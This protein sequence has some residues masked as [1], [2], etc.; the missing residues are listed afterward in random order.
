MGGLCGAGYVFVDCIDEI[1]AMNNRA[2]STTPARYL[3]EKG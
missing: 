2:A 3:D 1:I